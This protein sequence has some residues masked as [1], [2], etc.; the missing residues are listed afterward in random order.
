MKQYENYFI[1]LKRWHFQQQKFHDLRA[2]SVCTHHSF[3]QGRDL[4]PNGGLFTHSFML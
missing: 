2:S 4:F 3:G 1:Y